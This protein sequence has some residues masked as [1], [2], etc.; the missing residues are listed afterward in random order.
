MRFVRILEATIDIAA[1][2]IA[3]A[4]LFVLFVA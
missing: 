1:I 2:V 3:I 4:I